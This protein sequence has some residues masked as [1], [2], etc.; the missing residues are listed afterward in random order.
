M[1]IKPVHYKKK[2]SRFSKLCKKYI[3]YLK[4]LLCNSM[5][6]SVYV[7]KILHFKADL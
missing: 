7:L 4:S 5:E 6:Q 3:E 2:W 1:T